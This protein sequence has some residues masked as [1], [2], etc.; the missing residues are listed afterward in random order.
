MKRT[1][2]NCV[3]CTSMGMPCLGDACSNRNAVQYSCDECKEEYPPE[4]LFDFD[5]K[6]TELCAKCLLKKFDTIA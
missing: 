2:N 6:G 1:V 5:L 3:D 4:E